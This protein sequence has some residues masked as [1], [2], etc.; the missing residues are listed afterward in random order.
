MLFASMLC[1][2]PSFCPSLFQQGVRAG[3]HMVHF[4]MAYFAMLPAMSLNGYLVFAILIGTY[5]G[6]FVFSWE[7][8][9][10]R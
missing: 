7:S 8:G 5:M 4:G 1:A 9:A 6:S 10:T 2:S 3:I